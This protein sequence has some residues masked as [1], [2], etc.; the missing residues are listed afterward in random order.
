MIDE[1]ILKVQSLLMHHYSVRI[2]IFVDQLVENEIYMR[3]QN[4][5]DIQN[6]AP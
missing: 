4:P 3:Q 5:F 1:D 6:R 2:H